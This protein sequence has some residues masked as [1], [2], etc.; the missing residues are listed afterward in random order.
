MKLFTQLFLSLVL[1]LPISFAIVGCKKTVTEEK[2]TT[3]NPDGSKTEHKTNVSSDRDGNTT[4]TQ[5]DTV[6]KGK[7]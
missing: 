5:V 4:R 3:Q 7:N 6:E 2:T 1:A